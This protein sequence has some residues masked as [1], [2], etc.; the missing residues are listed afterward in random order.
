MQRVEPPA[1]PFVILEL[2]I[3]AVELIL[4]SEQ[5][6]EPEQQNSDPGRP[7]GVALPDVSLKLYYYRSTIP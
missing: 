5:V 3:V 1:G 4:L 6:I 7:E 2:A